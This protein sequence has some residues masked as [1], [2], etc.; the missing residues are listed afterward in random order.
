MCVEQEMYST[1]GEVF[2]IILVQMNN[3]EVGFIWNLD[4]PSIR[5]IGL[6]KSYMQASSNILTI[7]FGMFIVQI[8][9]LT[10]I[11][12]EPITVVFVYYYFMQDMTKDIH[13]CQHSTLHN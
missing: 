12:L 9:N 8:P 10:T 3:S 7:E 11:N 2:E 1:N 5:V 13:K 4:P 6:S